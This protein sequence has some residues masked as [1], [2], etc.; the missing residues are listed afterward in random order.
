M[1]T[2]LGIDPGQKNGLAIYEDGKLTELRTVSPLQLA[3]A[4]KDIAPAR[5]IFE[6]SR[7]TKAIFAR[8]VSP[9]AMRK[10]ARNVGEIDGLCGQ[11]TAICEDL[12]IPAHG[13]SPKGKGRKLDSLEFRAVTGWKGESNQHTRDAAMLVFRYRRGAA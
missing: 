12:G 8:G 2:I 9:A 13:I 5:V 4:I 10:I 6:D 3:A 7:L 11:I 1:T